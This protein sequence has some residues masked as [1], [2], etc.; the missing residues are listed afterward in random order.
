MDAPESDIR[1]GMSPGESHGS[2]GSFRLSTAS[3]FGGFLENEYLT[4]QKITR[5]YSFSF[6]QAKQIGRAHV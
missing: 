1:P 5:R 3:G 6:R 4:K 2:G